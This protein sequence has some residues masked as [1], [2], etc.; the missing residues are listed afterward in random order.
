MPTPGA[1]LAMLLLPAVGGCSCSPR[2]RSRPGVVPMSYFDLG[3]GALRRVPTDP[4]TVAVMAGLH[5]NTVASPARRTAPETCQH[6]PPG[7]A[8]ARIPLQ[9]RHKIGKR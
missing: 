4:V 2:E 9:D 8:M 3:D 6:W 5:R 1:P 7:P